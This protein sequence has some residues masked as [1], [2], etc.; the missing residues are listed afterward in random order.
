MGNLKACLN[1]GNVS[2][3]IKLS[4][5]YNLLTLLAAFAKCLKVLWNNIWAIKT[6]LKIAFY[7]TKWVTQ[8]RQ[9][10]Y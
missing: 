6:D 1:K 9:H 2:N 10:S 4:K 5:T 3:D 7:C 8:Q